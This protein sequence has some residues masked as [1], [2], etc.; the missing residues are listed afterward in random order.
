MSPESRSA[1]WLTRRIKIA[2][3]AV[4]CCTAILV[5]GSYVGLKIAE[6][7]LRSRTAAAATARLRRTVSVGDVTLRLGHATLRDVIIDAP[8]DSEPAVHVEWAVVT[9]ETSSLFGS[10]PVVVE[11]ILLDGITARLD[12]AEDGATSIDDLLARLRGSGADAEVGRP[13]RVVLP[14]RIDL[15]SARLEVTDRAGPFSSSIHV[16][17]GLLDRTTKHFALRGV[18]AEVAEDRIS[19][20]AS[21]NRDLNI[22]GTVVRDGT[23]GIRL[24]LEASYGAQDAEAW[25]A[26]GTA[27][28]ESVDLSVVLAGTSVAR[29]GELAEAFGSE[30]RSESKLSGMLNIHGDAEELTAR[31]D[32]RADQL[33]LSHPVLSSQPIEGI[34]GRAVLAV[35]IDRSARHVELAPSTVWLGREGQAA[36]FKVVARY[37]GRAGDRVA[38]LSAN[39]DLAP[40]EC[41]RVLGGLPRR[42]LAALNGF[43]VEG[44]MSAALALGIDWKNLE[45]TALHTD[46]KLD[47]CNVT[48]APARL[49]KAALESSFEHRVPV[50]ESWK[51]FTVGPASP[52]FAPLD[53]IATHLQRSIIFTEDPG[54]LKHAGFSD[55]FRLALIKNL[56]LGRFA[57]GASSITN[58]LVKNLFLTRDKTIARK[59]QEYALTWHVERTISKD[60]ILEMY[61][62]AIEFGPGIYGI[63]PAS[64]HYFDKQPRRLNIVESAFFSTILPAPVARFRQFCDGDVSEWTEDK[65]ERIVDG[66]FLYKRL[67]EE[68]Y[69]EALESGMHFRRGG[70]AG[71]CA[72]QVLAKR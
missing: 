34:D 17:S 23:A 8:M 58:Q 57:W 12:R 7:K 52:D 46:I 55:E 69:Y 44:T 56:R 35:S 16:A 30:P 32:L 53:A 4:V 50:G 60:R 13:S 25:T 47:D 14:Q 62:N 18:E 65:I 48:R 40:T 72:E 6:G 29:A 61:L 26:R 11:S 71:M 51:T 63:K 24:D 64:L 59:F 37:Q 43:E 70:V 31:G 19:A 15:Q 36:E 21:A 39:V 9:F 1:V 42:S 49:T 38:T 2:T 68:Q 5:G 20:L 41:A 10:G 33:V 66:Q 45:K 3:A 28:A 27:S 67:T 22:A 54:F